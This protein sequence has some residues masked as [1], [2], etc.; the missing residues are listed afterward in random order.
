MLTKRSFGDNGITNLEIGNEDVGETTSVEAGL[1]K[2]ARE[3]GESFMLSLV[4]N[5][6]IGNALVLETPFP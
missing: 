4:P 5:L 1:A 3:R 6:Q 2:M